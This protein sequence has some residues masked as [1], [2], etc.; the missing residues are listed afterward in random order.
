MPGSVSSV[1]VHAEPSQV[2]TSIE[3]PLN[4]ESDSPTATQCVEEAQ[5]TAASWAPAKSAGSPVPEAGSRS[6]PSDRDVPARKFRF[7][8]EGVRSGTNLRWTLL[9][10]EPAPDD[11]LTGHLRKRLNRLINASLRYSYG[12]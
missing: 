7:D 5:E 4:S 3:S 1:G 6:S 9:V 12:Q 10:D 8:L 11:S 2:S